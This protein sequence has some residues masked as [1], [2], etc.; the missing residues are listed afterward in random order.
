MTDEG[1]EVKLLSSSDISLEFLVKGVPL[2]ILNA[3]RR[4]A[5]AKVPSMAVD[6][7]MVIANTSALFD[8]IIAHRLGL[9]PL[10]SEEAIK[11][12]RDPE[13]CA[14]CSQV[15]GGEEG[16]RPPPEVCRECFVHMYLEAS[17]DRE[18][19]TVYSGDIKSE[20]PDVYPV[21]DNIPLVVLAPGQRL[22]LE[23]R[24]R[25]GRG[26]EH[27]KW[28]PATVAVVRYVADIS[29][30]EKLCTGCGEC[31][32]VCPRSVLELS[33]G[34]VRVTNLMNCIICRQC[35][36][37]CEPRALKVGY[38]ND[39]YVVYIES[40]GALKPFTIV[41]EALNILIGELDNLIKQAME[42]RGSSRAETGGES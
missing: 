17:A 21:Y 16:Q 18:S 42:W 9:I 24:A 40:S 31:V 35:E 11:K 37:V 13:T 22:I 28:S 6:E 12:Y 3:I 33:G 25:L 29:I 38:R 32:K 36:K 19:V 14:R 8:E 41:R 27:A 7:V 15:E 30:D 5:L 10:Y 34:K 2:P 23:M 20:D 26:L 1:I 39:E 4:Y